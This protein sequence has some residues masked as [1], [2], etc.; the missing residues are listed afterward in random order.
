MNFSNSFSSFLY[1]IYVYIQVLFFGASPWIKLFPGHFLPR[2]F[3]RDRQQACRYITMCVP[4]SSDTWAERTLD[5]EPQKLAQFSGVRLP[6]W[7]GQE[8]TVET[9]EY[10]AWGVL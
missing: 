9:Y 5:V 10:A 1:S 7:Q 2:F 4:C 6:S 3:F 8:K